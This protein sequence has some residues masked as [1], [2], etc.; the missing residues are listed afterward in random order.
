[1]PP[2]TYGLPIWVWRRRGRRRRARRRAPRCRA[3]CG[4]RRRGWRACPRRLGRL[5]LGGQGVEQLLRVGEL[6]LDFFF[7]SPSVLRV[8][9][10]SSSLPCGLLALLREGPL[11]LLDLLQRLDLLSAQL[12]ERGR[13]VEVV[14]RVGGEEELDGGVDRAGAV[15]GAGHQTEAV[16]HG[17]ELVLASRDLVLDGVDLFFELFLLL[18]GPVGLV[19]GAL[20]LFVELV[21]L[22]LDLGLARLLAGGGVGRLR[23]E[24]HGCS[25]G[26]GE[27]GHAGAAR[28]LRSTVG[29][30]GGELLHYLSRL[31]K[32]PVGGAPPPSLPMSDHPSRGSTP[33]PSD[34]LVISSNPPR[35]NLGHRPHS[36]H[37]THMQ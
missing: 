28:L 9:A 23:A 4:R 36:L 12:V 7:F 22:G 5:L 33:D 6:A 11:L 16:A 15:L 2:E 10:R 13:L 17:V 1:M 25:G 31:P 34:V 21:D 32:T 27:H 30:H 29:R 14:V 26:G 8:S 37:S 19:G 18:L 3:R 20:H 35:K 24:G